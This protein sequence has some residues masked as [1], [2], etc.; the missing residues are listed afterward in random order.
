MKVRCDT[1]VVL[2]RL[3]ELKLDPKNRNIHP[4]EQIVRLAKILDAHGWRYPVKV[5]NQSGFVR[6]GHGRILAALHNG[7]AEVP[8]Q[9]QDYASLDEEYAD[10]IAD[11]A[12]ASWSDLDLEGITL[13]IKDLSPDLDLELLGL[14]SFS[15]LPPGEFEAVDDSSRDGP[16]KYILEI[17]F[18]NEM[19]MADIRDDLTSRGYIVKEV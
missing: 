15:L 12:V 1:P 7:W 6:S 14:K 17:T 10:S 13:D 19:E 16:K 5:S 2:V 8:V 9:Y 11:N 3:S 18:P 4:P